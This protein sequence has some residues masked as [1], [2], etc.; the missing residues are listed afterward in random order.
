MASQR[1]L[2][3]QQRKRIHD[4]HRQWQASDADQGHSGTVVAHFGGEVL[5]ET[6]E[7]KR[8]DRQRRMHARA[9]LGG[10][11]AG[12]RV[13]WHED[14]TGEG[15]VVARLERHGQLQR[16][17][18]FGGLRTVAANVDLLILVIAPEPAPQTELVDRYLAAAEI[19]DLDVVI[20]LNK[21]DLLEPDMEERTDPLLQRYTHLGYRIE[22]TSARGNEA[23]GKVPDF[24]NQRTSVI[25]GQSGVGKSSLIKQWLP[26]VELRIGELSRHGEGT[27]TTTTPHLYRLRGGGA[28][29]DSPGIR[30]FGL[31]HMTPEDITRGFVDVRQWLGYCRF[32]DCRHRNEPGCALKQAV[33]RGELHPQ[34]FEHYL[35]L[36]DEAANQ[37]PTS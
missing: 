20:L 32:R 2:S 18:R 19:Y 6:G 1:K 17:N 35:R 33:E 37:T 15:V 21:A 10:L 30:E 24:L 13:V 22:R 34:R 4:R 3:R 31:W 8:E 11:V 25:G 26:D 36:H 9:N 12:D 16:P 27:H 5:I 7:E 28:I 14:D 29:I 23:I